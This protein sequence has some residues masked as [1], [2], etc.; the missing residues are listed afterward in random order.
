MKCGIMRVVFLF[1]M[2]LAAASSAA[3]ENLLV[4]EALSDSS[5]KPLLQTTPDGRAIPVVQRAADN[6]F[7]DSVKAALSDG[8]GAEMLRLQQVVDERYQLDNP[9]WLML[10]LED[11]GY[12]RRGFYL[13]EDGERILHDVWYV[14]ML[15]DPESV[16]SG[17]FEEIW[18]H[19]TA[20]VLLGLVMAELPRTANTMHQSMALTDD[21]VAVD[22]G[23]AIAMQPL[24][25]QRSTNAILRATD[26]GLRGAGYTEYWLSKHDQHLRHYGVK[27][28]LF[29]HSVVEPPGGD[30]L[31]ERYRRTQSSS[32]F[33]R[34]ELRTAS[35]LLASEGYLATVFYRL[36]QQ[37]EIAASVRHE[38]PTLKQLSDWQLVT[39]RLLSV[40]KQSELDGDT[41]K[42]AAQIFEGWRRLYPRDW[43]LVV[44][45]VL[46]TSFGATADISAHQQFEAVAEAGLQG[47]MQALIAQLPSAR[48]WLAGLKA[49][50]VSGELA[51]FGAAGEPL[52]IENPSFLVGNAL[53]STE[54][55][56]PLRVNLN[57]AMEVELETLPM[58]GAEQ[59]A[60]IVDDRRRNG[61]YRSLA[62]VCGRAEL[63]RDDCDTLRKMQSG[64]SR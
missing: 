55:N 21:V 5:G 6:Q 1:A 16:A 35:Q 10:S 64:L 22:E 27:H 23:L 41:G 58:I 49:K 28:N 25:R 24:A 31:F 60:I 9:V 19:E 45:V 3:G 44:D 57:T 54:R 59:A 63:T 29:A 56:Q 20:H 15:V 34:Y 17:Q 61:D 36:L 7:S 13:Q 2:T 40:V 50:I 18:T 26:R 33:N 51:L 14:D 11:G 42:L 32:L 39:L 43:P 12:A 52:W 8:F 4:V 37:P 47:D 30:S 62:D 38:L 48:T 53:W 46:E